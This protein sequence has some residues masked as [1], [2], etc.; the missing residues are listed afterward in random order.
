MKSVKA[1]IELD[2]IGPQSSFEVPTLILGSFAG[3]QITLKQPNLTVKVL[4]NTT[5]RSFDDVAIYAVLGKDLDFLKEGLN[6]SAQKTF[7][8][9][10]QKIKSGSLERLG[11]KLFLAGKPE[12]QQF[13]EQLTS[14][15]NEFFKKYL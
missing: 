14:E 9:E 1:L 12:M 4:D 15:V 5:S 7:D 11:E 3:P 8:L 6:T 2:L 13:L 10:V